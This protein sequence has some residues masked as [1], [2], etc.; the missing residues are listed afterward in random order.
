MIY[1][2]E[3]AFK[4]LLPARENGLEMIKLLFMVIAYVAEKGGQVLENS[5]NTRV[6][7]ED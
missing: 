4:F 6:P 2:C 3:N 5:Q 7:I 1:I